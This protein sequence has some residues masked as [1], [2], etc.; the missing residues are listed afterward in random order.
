M[1]KIKKPIASL[2]KNEETMA[3]ARKQ[4]KCKCNRNGKKKGKK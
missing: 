3:A 4:P 1:I 2:K